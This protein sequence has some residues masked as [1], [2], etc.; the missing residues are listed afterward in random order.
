M[1]GLKFILP[2]AAASV[3]SA[4]ASAGDGGPVSANLPQ[5]VPGNN[6]QEVCRVF[7]AETCI[8]HIWTALD[9]D[10]DSLLSADEIDTFVARADRWIKISDKSR[11]DKAV[12]KVAT[13]VYGVTGIEKLIK[14]YDMDADGMLSPEE[15]FADFDLD[16]RP[17]AEVLLDNGAVDAEQL[18]DRFGFMAPQLVKLAQAAGSRLVDGTGGDVTAIAAAINADELEPEQASTDQ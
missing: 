9:S 6:T 15:A 4:S 14:S 3:L 18:A 13:M 5:L 11:A 1:R 17:I 12:V 7:S 16:E 10:G 8:S 2:L